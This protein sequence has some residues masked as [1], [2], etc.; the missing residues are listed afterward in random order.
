MDEISII[1]FLNTFLGT[2]QENRLRIIFSGASERGKKRDLD[3]KKIEFG[4]VMVL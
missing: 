4:E 3:H 1:Y 2:G